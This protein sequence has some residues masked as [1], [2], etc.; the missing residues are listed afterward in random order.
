ME[1]FFS[2]RILFGEDILNSMHIFAGSWLDW[3]MLGITSAGSEMFYMLSLPV[4][5]WCWDRKK[6]LYTGAAFLIGISVN[7]FLK[8]VFNNPRPD[9][10]KLLPGIAELA[11]RFRPEGPG[12]PSGHAQGSLLFWGTIGLLSRPRAAKA[13]RV[14]MIILI[15]YSRLH[16]AVHYLGDVIGGIVF[17]AACFALI[18]PAAKLTERYYHSVGI[19]ILT[20]LLLLVPFLI[21][22]IVPGAHINT[23]MGTISGFMIGALSGEDRIRFNPRNG[24]AASLAKIAIGL[25]VVFAIRFGLKPALPDLLVSGFFRYWL[26]GFW[27][28]FG[29]P[30]VFG[31]IRSLRGDVGE[32]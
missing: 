12:F 31:K 21:Y 23:T 19:V 3:L 2:N 4:L 7:D 16:L 32:G 29:A 22:N 15:P 14:A 26:I 11:V 25:A 18:F 17:G 10:A 13:F 28:S 20:G 9:P 24:V 5:Y 1:I 8:V 30:Y 27:C 6:A